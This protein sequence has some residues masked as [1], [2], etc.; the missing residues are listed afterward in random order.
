MNRAYKAMILLFALGGALGYAGAYAEY[1]N[2]RNHGA[3]YSQCKGEWLALAALPGMLLT[4]AYRRCDYG[5]TE[6]WLIDKHRIALCNAVS[7]AAV[8]GILLGVRKT[9]KRRHHRTTG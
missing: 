4:Q 6:A 9:I 7:V 1:R 2:E 8:G 3:E 5:L